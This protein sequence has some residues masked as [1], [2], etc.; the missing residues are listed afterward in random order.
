MNTQRPVLDVS[1]LG[2]SYDGKPAVENISFQTFPGQTMAL[3]GE[4]GSGKSTI[5]KAIVQMLPPGARL[6]HG[7]ITLNGISLPDATPRGLNAIR[8]HQIGFIPQDPSSSLDPRLPV[9]RQIEEVLR[10]HTSQSRAER[11]EHILHLLEHVGFSEPERRFS[12]FP[13]ELSGGMKQ[14]VLIAIAVAL[15]PPLIIA[16]EPTSALDVTIQSQ[17]LD[18]LDRL[19]EESGSSVLMITHDLAVARDRAHDMIVLRHGQIAEQNTTHNLFESPRSS[20]TRKLLADSPAFHSRPARRDRPVSGMQPAIQVKDLTIAYGSRTAVS[21]LSFDVQ[22][23]TTH[24]IIGESG[25]GKTT[26]LRCLMGLIPPQSGSVHVHGKD[27]FSETSAERRQRLRSMQLVYQNP[28]SSLDPRLTIRRIIEEPLRNY[29]PEGHAWRQARLHDLLERV[30]L[31][32]ALLERYP[33]EISGGQ[34]QRVA[35]ARA[36][37]AQPDILVLDEFV[38]ALDVTVQARILELLSELQKELN[39]TFVFVSHDLAVVR[40][41]ADTLSIIRYGKQKEYGD[42]EHIFR[43]PAS[44]YTQTLLR[45]IPGQK[46]SEQAKRKGSKE[47]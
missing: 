30:H 21:H 11:R 47:G 13:H 41:I 35:L 2:I 12:Q 4:S 29:F 31:P 7:T 9:G 45:A 25:S 8:G 1:H 27:I 43:E 5:A 44:P 46:H 14:R 20:Y 6:M 16:D 26:L 10:L 36:L 34:C 3:I 38:S 18:L 22:P 40:Q 32:L 15:A 23:G 28:W 24:G 19:R 39:L 33:S 17:I 37:A 42:A